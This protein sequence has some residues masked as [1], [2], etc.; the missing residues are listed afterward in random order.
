MV[1]PGDPITVTEATFGTTVRV[2]VGQIIQVRLTD[3]RPIPGSSLVW[4]VSSSDPAILRL[5]SAQQGAAAPMRDSVY[6]ATFVAR[7][8]GTA[9]LHAAGATTCEAMLKSAC[10]DRAAEITVEVT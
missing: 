1:S 4:A 8:R 3:S 2:L 5:Q 10:P 6:S 9:R 7:G